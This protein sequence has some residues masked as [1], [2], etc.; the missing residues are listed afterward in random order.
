MRLPP[1]LPS[2]P[3]IGSLLDLRRDRLATFRRAMALGDVVRLRFPGVEGVLLSHPEHVRKVFI[4]EHRAFGK[5]TR[6]Y[7][8]LRIALGNGLVTSE[9]SFWRRQRRIAQPGFHRRRI[10]AFAETMTRATE[11]MLARWQKRPDP[12]SPLDIGHEMMGLTFRIVGECLM[13]TDLSG[14][15]SAVGEAVTTLLK[16]TVDRTTRPVLLPLE[17]PT[18]KNKKL[19]RAL[20]VLDSL[21]LDIIARRRKS[22][23][24]PG[25]LLDMLMNTEDEETGERMTDRQLRDEIV[26]LV[27]AG[28]E[29]T[30]AG[31]T[32]SFYLLSTHPAELRRL[33]EELDEVLPDRRIPTNDDLSRLAYTRA[34]FS[35]A[36][37]L[38][39]PIWFVAR[40]VHE[41]IDFGGYDVRPGQVVFISPMLIHHDRRFFPNPEGFEPERFLGEAEKAIP[42]HAYIPF[43]TGPRQCIGNNFAIMEAQLILATVLPRFDLELVTGTSVIAEPT[44][45]LRPKYG[46]PMIVTP[47]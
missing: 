46:L 34:V 4:D 20:E 26:T 41:P 44:V 45:T 17:V 12:E 8:T 28:H 35:E 43:I 42:K 24:R 13:G 15:A 14:E 3:I 38:Y 6:G 33:R 5:Q 36:M 39:P 7:N 1:L 23:E 32:W 16:A 30:A 10:A 27:L 9:G 18:P 2:P 40:S 22:G 37:R 11:D 31:L 25:D 29:T 21:V 19:K 47:R